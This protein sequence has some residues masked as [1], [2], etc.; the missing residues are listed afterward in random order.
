MFEQVIYNDL[1]VFFISLSDSANGTTLEWVFI[2]PLEQSHIL[3]AVFRQ[4]RCVCYG[5]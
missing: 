5:A 2:G 3:N 1:R 4:A